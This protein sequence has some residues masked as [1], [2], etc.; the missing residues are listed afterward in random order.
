MVVAIHPSEEIG[1]ISA[2]LLFDRMSGAVTGA[3]VTVT[4]PMKIVTR[5]IEDMIA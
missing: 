3:P 2:R 5:A 1:R 4:V